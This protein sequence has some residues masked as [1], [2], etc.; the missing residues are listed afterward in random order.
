MYRLLTVL[1]FFL[2]FKPVQLFATGNN[3]ITL[4]FITEANATDCNNFILLQWNVADNTL[5]DHYEI[6]RMDIDGT[7]QTIAMILSDNL[8]ETERYIYKDKI[9]V[10]DLQL[11]YR[12]KVLLTGGEE[13][14]S[15]SFVIEPK[16][17][18]NSL[19]KMLYMPTENA[20]NM[21][22]PVGEADYVYRFYN[23][24]GKMTKVTSAK[25]QTIPVSDLKRGSY[26]VEAFQPQTGKRYY[27]EFRK[28]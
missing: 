21:Y 25:N 5:A 15:N 12:I 9:T 10:R 28:E 23:I 13:Q 17:A 24:M 20:V 1:V 2:L 16:S 14:Y 18:Q 7:Y 4:P 3:N 27:G 8:Q 19:A 11:Q 26:F 6:Q 22:L